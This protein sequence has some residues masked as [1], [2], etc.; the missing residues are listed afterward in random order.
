MLI[1]IKNLLL[2]I[3]VGNDIVA[4]IFQEANTPFSPDMIASHFLHAFVVVEVIDP[5]G[6]NTK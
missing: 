5:H 2:F 4:V 6:P 1:N 3:I